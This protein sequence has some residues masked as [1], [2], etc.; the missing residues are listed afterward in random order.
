MIVND[1]DNPH[2]GTDAIREGI[3]EAMGMINQK[4]K[5]EQADLELLHIQNKIH[6]IGVKFSK[7]V[8]RMK[9]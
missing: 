1:Y 8:N 2:A 3:D 4:A 7:N 9:N 6:N 5:K